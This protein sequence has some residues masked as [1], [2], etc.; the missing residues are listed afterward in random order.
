MCR[1][2]TSDSGLARRYGFDLA[3]CRTVRFTPG[4]PSLQALVASAISPLLPLALLSTC[5]LPESASE[6]NEN[7]HTD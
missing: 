5:I 6:L 2:G 7:Y 3:P 4:L 1:G